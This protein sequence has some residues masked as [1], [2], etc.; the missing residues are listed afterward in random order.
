MQEVA[1]GVACLPIVFVNAYF[2]GKPGGPWILIDSGIPNKANMIREA[3]QERYGAG[4]KP[5]A[6]YLTH[7]H[8]DH[9]GSALEL[10]VGWDVPIY[11]HPLEMPYLTGKSSYPPPDPTIGGFIAFGSRFMPK[12]PLNLSSRL[13]ELPPDGAVP[14]LSGWRWHFTPGHSPGHVSYFREADATLIAGDAVATMDMDSWIGALTKKQQ[15]AKAGACFNCDWQATRQSVEQLAALHP[16]T[17]AAGHGVPMQGPHLPADFEFFATN[18]QAP[19]H[20]RYIY[21]PAQTNATG[22]VAL[23]PAP[24]DPLPKMAAT[25]GAVA[26]VSALLLKQ[27]KRENR[28]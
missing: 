21:E 26:L 1:A 4:S 8:F 13:R 11:A 7:G 24:P 18:L 9:A 20:G 12:H 15:L 10:A 23:P 2:V 22:V 5:E 19:A 16:M 25:L 14:E 28:V 27:R 6:I 3:A 17:I